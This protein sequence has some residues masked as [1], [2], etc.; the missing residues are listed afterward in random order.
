[1]SVPRGEEGRVQAAGSGGAP[2]FPAQERVDLAELEP[3]S[4]AELP[5]RLATAR[6]ACFPTDTVYGIGGR[7]SPATAAAVT[8]AKRRDRGKPLQVIFPNREA[9]F[10]A[11]ALGRRLTD[12]CLRLLPGPVTLV[13]PYPEGFDGPPAGEVVHE[14]RRAIGADGRIV[15]RT[16]GVRVPRWPTPA[17][18]LGA[19]TFPLVSS[20]AN[21]SGAPAPAR[22]VD[23]DPGILAACDLVLDA[24]PA[25]GAASTVV[26]LT[27][28]EERGRWR[29][30]REGA[31]TADDV[32]ERL[33]RRRDDLPRV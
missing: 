12:A 31:L 6:L 29:L 7:L 13:I 18:V 3:G 24:G 21:R 30:L 22:L 1:M 17:R 2:A 9:L 16:L 23:V 25:G 8:A 5:L 11:V 4:A 32:A 27:L 20:S 26:D 15:V 10:A 14:Q 33:A 28:Y 19:L